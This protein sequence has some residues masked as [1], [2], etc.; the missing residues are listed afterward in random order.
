MGYWKDILRPLLTILLV[1]QVSLAFAL[2]AGIHLNL[3]IGFNGH[4][5]IG[6]DDCAGSLE[7]QRRAPEPVFDFDDHHDECVDV[8]IGCPSAD[9]VVRSRDTASF[10]KEKGNH[11]NFSAVAGHFNSAL[12]RDAAPFAIRRSFLP[13]GAT[14]TPSHLDS[15]RTIVLL[16]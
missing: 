6:P 5:E 15:L 2:P 11:N 8:A 14:L 16:I 12:S 9:K 1:M 13:P 4:V 10:A 3:C 7:Q